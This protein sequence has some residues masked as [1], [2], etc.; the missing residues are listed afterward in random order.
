VYGE[1]LMLVV[2]SGGTWRRLGSGN[3]N[4]QRLDHESIGVRDVGADSEGWERIEEWSGEATRR[5]VVEG[6]E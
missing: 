3:S 1:V 2:Q 5:R 6:G 4:E